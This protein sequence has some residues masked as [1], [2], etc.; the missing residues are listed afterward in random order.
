MVI[1]GRFKDGTLS[2][3]GTMHLRDGT[4]LLQRITWTT[5][6]SGVRE[7]SVVSKNGGQTWEPSFDVLFQKHR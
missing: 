5:E 6:G 7:S 1:A 4:S 2:L 3:K